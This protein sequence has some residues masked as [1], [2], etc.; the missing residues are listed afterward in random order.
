MKNENLF[1]EQ[2]NLNQSHLPKDFDIKDYTNSQIQ[3]S[4]CLMV[5]YRTEHIENRAFA[6]NDIWSSKIDNLGLVF[7]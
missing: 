4:I 1:V 3:H 7:I 6:M 2:V 5:E